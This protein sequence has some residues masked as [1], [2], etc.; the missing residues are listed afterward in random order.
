MSGLVEK[1][2]FAALAAGLH[3]L[4]FA[5]VPGGGTQSR[6]AG[7]ERLVTLQ[8]AT[9]QLS[10]M[11][12]DWQ[13]P[14]EVAAAPELAAL[15]RPPD[16]QSALDLPQVTRPDRPTAQVARPDRPRDPVDPRPV[17][18]ALPH[19]TAPLADAPALPSIAA[20]S[21]AAPLAPEAPAPVA[22]SRP[23][24]TMKPDIPAPASPPEMS[25]VRETAA[26]PAPA[27]PEARPQ[28]QSRPS[29]PAAPAQKAAGSGGA[30][31]AGTGGR[32]DTA[33]LSTGQRRS[34]VANWG[35][36]IRT[37]IERR[38]RHPRDVRG[39]GRVVLTLQVDRNGDLQSVAVRQSSGNPK[40]DAAAVQAV[41]RAGRFPAA[42]DGLKDPVYRFSLPI[43]FNG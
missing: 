9:P 25:E 18:L 36:R 21:G 16:Q 34:L 14:P 33:T 28:R 13:A 39:G 12:A 20:D 22:V 6:G 29:A 32:A 3:V 26:P 30:K 11:V 41:R 2:V 27:K 43:R 38:K 17:P 35:A 5:A 10:A 40:L 37:K 15:A 19:P 23:T 42:P 1:T 8:G 31:Q 4:A 24:A 7:G